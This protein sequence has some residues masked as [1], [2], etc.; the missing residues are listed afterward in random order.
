M[1]VAFKNFSGM[2]EDQVVSLPPEVRQMVMTGTNAMM[3]GAANQGLMNPGMMMDMSGMMPMGM[4]MPGDMGMMS[5]DGG[6]GMMVP[7]ASA[8]QGV[9]NPDQGMSG[10]PGEGYTGNASNGVMGMGM[11]GEMPD[12]SQ[13]NQQMYATPDNSGHGAMRGVASGPSYRGAGR[14]QPS[15]RGFTSRGRGR[16]GYPTGML[17]SC[18]FRH[19]SCLNRC[20][21]VP[22]CLCDLHLLSR[23][24]YPQ[25]RETKTSIRIAMAMPKLWMDWIMEVTRMVVGVHQANNQ[26]TVAGKISTTSD[27]RQI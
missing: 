8:R 17:C 12:P 16:G 19:S 7:D 11:A 25:G 23:R 21:K 13:T 6:N 20:A 18:S 15:G 2:S 1:L 9:G 22:P 14:G 24:M 3:N 5:M 27:F 4:A 10:I 26:R